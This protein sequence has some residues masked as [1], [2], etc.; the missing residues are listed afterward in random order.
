MNLLHDIMVTNRIKYLKDN[1]YKG[2]RIKLLINNVLPSF[3][4]NQ[5]INK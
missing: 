5:F 2:Y 3:L 4:K 1:N